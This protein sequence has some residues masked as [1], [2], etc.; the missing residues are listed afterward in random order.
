MLVDERLNAYMISLYP[1]LP[2]F[3][4]EIEEQAHRTYVP[5]IRK[6]VQQY[7]RFLLLQQPPAQILEIGTATGFSALFMAWCTPAQ[8]KITTIENS[9]KR[10]PIAK[11]HFAQSAYAER[12]RLLE[13]DAHEILP[14]LEGSYDFIFLDAAKGQYLSFLPHLCRLLS[15][16]GLLVSDNALQDGSVSLPRYAVAHR[17][18]TTHTR[19]REFLYALTHSDQMQTVVLPVGDGLTVSLKRKNDEKTGTSDAG[20]QCGDSENCI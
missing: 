1:D 3:L 2:E 14:S 15:P 13:G 17:D 18:R 5:V 19:M 16:G 20:R 7:L 6:D 10:I 12:I 4:N 11:Q 9:E 8:T